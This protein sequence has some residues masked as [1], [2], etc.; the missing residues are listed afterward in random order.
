MKL[1]LAA[2]IASLYTFFPDK[3]VADIFEK[4]KELRANEVRKYGPRPKE[5]FDS[6][7][8]ILSVRASRAFRC[9]CLYGWELGIINA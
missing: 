5:K 1:T 7:I 2:N 6:G 8:I 9:R 4:S 3:E